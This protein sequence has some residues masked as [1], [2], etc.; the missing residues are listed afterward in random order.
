MITMLQPIVSRQ[1]TT[2]EPVVL[3]VT[4]INGG[5]TWNVLPEQVELEGTVRTYNEEIRRQIPIQMTRIIEGIAAGAGAEAQLHWYPGPPA[6]VNDGEWADFTKEIA[7]HAGY[8]VHVCR[9]NIAATPLR[10]PD[11]KTLSAPCPVSSAGWNSTLT[12]PG[13]S[14]SRAFNKRAAP[15]IVAV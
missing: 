6:T 4:R 2:T 12:L 11:A 13:N 10:P 1:N 15:K 5:F 8:E 14:L 9:P 7:L 3:S